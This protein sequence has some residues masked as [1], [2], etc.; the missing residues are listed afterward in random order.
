MPSGIFQNLLSRL[1]S[2]FS[3][4][5]RS[6][7][8]F[9][10]K[11][12]AQCRMVIAD[13][14]LTIT[15]VN[16]T[17]PL[18]D[19]S[20][21]DPY[22]AQKNITVKQVF[23]LLNVTPG[24]T[25]DNL[26]T[27]VA[28][29]G[30]IALV[31][32]DYILT[33]DTMNPVRVFTSLL[34]AIYRPLA[35]V[36]E[37]A[38]GDIDVAI[39]QLGFVTAQGDF[40]DY[41]GTFFNIPRYS[42]VSSQTTTSLTAG[43]TAGANATL[44]VGN[45]LG[46]QVGKYILVGSGTKNFERVL[47][48]TVPD[49]V[50][51]TANL[52]NNHDAGEPIAV[53]NGVR[54]VE[55]DYEYSIR[56]LWETIKP[57]L[58]NKAIE[59][60]LFR[61][62]GYNTTVVDMSSKVLLAD[63][64]PTPVDKNPILEFSDAHMV[65]D[66]FLTSTT[67]GFP[68][69]DVRYGLGERYNFGSIGVFV[70]IPVDHAFYPYT[71]EQIQDIVER[72]RAG[73]TTPW[74]TVNQVAKETFSLLDEVVTQLQA[75]ISQ[76]I[77]EG[78]AMLFG[79]DDFQFYA[80][81]FSSDSVAKMPWLQNNLDK[82]SL[83]D[84]VVV[85]SQQVQVPA[86]YQSNNESV[87]VSGPLAD[88]FLGGFNRN[89]LVGDTTSTSDDFQFRTINNQTLISPA[90]TEFVDNPVILN[91]QRFSD[92]YITPRVLEG[93]TSDVL[94]FSAS[95]VQSLSL[96]DTTGV[97]A[98][99][100]QTVNLLYHNFPGN[101]NYIQWS[102][103]FTNPIWTFVDFAPTVTANATVDPLGGNTADKIVF[104]ATDATHTSR[105]QQF[106][107]IPTPAANTFYTI[108]VWLRADTAVNN[109]SLIM[110][111]STQAIP[112]SNTP[113]ITTSWQR[114]TI[115]G[116]GGFD[117][118][119][120]IGIQLATSTNQPS[121]TIYAWGAQ[122][123]YGAS[124]STYLRS[125]SDTNPFSNGQRLLVA[126][127]PNTSFNQT[128]S[129]TSV[130]THNQVTA[131]VVRPS[132]LTNDGVRVQTHGGT[133][134]AARKWAW[135]AATNSTQIGDVIHEEVLITNNG[136]NTVRVD[137]HLFLAGST[138]TVA[139]GQTLKVTFDQTAT[140]VSTVGM[141]FGSLDGTDIDITV[142]KP[143]ITV[144]GSTLGVQSDFV[145]GSWVGLAGATAT[146]IPNQPEPYPVPIVD[147]GI[148]GTISTDT[149]GVTGLSELTGVIP[150]TDTTF[151]V[152]LVISAPT[153]ITGVKFDSVA[154]TQA[155][156]RN[157][158]VV[159]R[160]LEMANFGE[161]W[162]TN[163]SASRYWI[164]PLQDVNGN[165]YYM[166]IAWPYKSPPVVPALRIS[167]PTASI[168]SSKVQIAAGD[169][170][171]ITW[172]A[173]NSNGTVTLRQET[174]ATGA[175]VDLPVAASGTNQ[176][177]TGGGN[178]ITQNTR[179]HLIVNGNNG[180]TAE[181]IVTITI[182]AAST[183]ALPP[184]ITLTATP[185]VVE[186]C[187][188][189][190]TLVNYT[191]D[192]NSRQTETQIILFPAGATSVVLH[193]NAGDP[194]GTT[195]LAPKQ[196]ANGTF[197]PRQL[198]VNRLSDG[199]LIPGAWSGLET[200]AATFIPVDP[201]Q[202]QGQDISVNYDVN[203]AGSVL[204][205]Q[206]TDV[207]LP[208]NGNVY[209]I[210]QQAK[211]TLPPPP[212]F[213]TSQTT[214]QLLN[215]SDFENMATPGAFWNL[216]GEGEVLS[217]TVPFYNLLQWSE[218]L[219]Y[220]PWTHSGGTTIT[221]DSQTD[222][223]GT[224]FADAIAFTNTSDFVSQNSGVVPVVG[225]TYTFSIWLKAP[226]TTLCQ[227]EMN[228]S[229]LDGVSLGV[230]VTTTWTRFSLTHTATSAGGTNP[231]SVLL[232]TTVNGSTVYAWGAQL[233][234]SA[235]ATTYQRRLSNIT[236][237]SVHSG[238]QCLRVDHTQ[239]ISFYGVRQILT[240]VNQGANFDF[241]ACSP[242][243]TI[244]INAWAY[245]ESFSNGAAPVILI[246][247]WNSTGAQITTAA[248]NQNSL[249]TWANIFGNLVV[250][251][252]AASFTMECYMGL[253][254][255]IGR[256]DDI[257]L[258]LTH[259]VTQT[260]TQYVA[261]YSV[262][263]D[264]YA[265]APVTS[266]IPVYV[267]TVQQG[268]GPFVVQSMYKGAANLIHD[269]NGLLGSWTTTAAMIFNSS[270]GALTGGGWQ[271]TGTGAA[272]G[273]QFAYSKVINVVPGQTYTLS[274]YIDGTNVTVGSPVWIV[275]DPSIPATN[276]AIATATQT[277]GVSGRITK[278]FT[279][280]AG[281]TQ[282]VVLG[283]TNNC[284]VANGSTLTF[285]NP[286]LEVGSTATPYANFPLTSITEAIGPTIN[287][288]V[289]VTLAGTGF[290]SKM[291]VF[292]A[293]KVPSQTDPT[294]FISQL[295]QA[296]IVSL[297]WQNGVLTFIAPRLTY[298]TAGYPII[299]NNIDC[300]GR[301]IGTDSSQVLIY[302]RSSYRDAPVIDA[303]VPS[304]TCLVAGFVNKTVSLTG[305][306]FRPGA[307]VYI[308]NMTTQQAYTRYFNTVMGLRP[309][310]Y[311]KLSETGVGAVY[312]DQSGNNNT[313]TL[314]GTATTQN[315]AGLI[316]ATANGSVTFNGS[317]SISAANSSTLQNNVVTIVLWV[318]AANTS[319]VASLA[320]LINQSG[321]LTTSPGWSIHENDTTTGLDVR[322]DTSAGA[323]QFT[324]L[325]GVVLDGNVHMVA[326]AIDGSA[327]NLSYSIDGAAYTT[328]TFLQGTGIANTTA[329]LMMG[330]LVGGGFLVGTIDEVALFSRI[331]PAANIATLY[332]QGTAHMMSETTTVVNQ[333]SLYFTMDITD[334]GSYD[335]I[336]ENTDTSSGATK[337][338]PMVLMPNHTIP[339]IDQFG[340]LAPISV[341]GCA[342]YGTPFTIY[343]SC[344]KA[345]SVS[346]LSSDPA[347]QTALQPPPSASWPAVGSV[348]VPIT[349][350]G[351]TV[352]LIATNDCNNTASS[353][354]T[355]ND[356]ACDR[357]LA[358]NIV[359]TP[360][361]IKDRLAYKLHTQRTSLNEATNV[362]SI[363][364]IS[365]DTALSYTL[366]DA[367]DNPIAATLLTQGVA[368][369]AVTLTDRYVTANKNGIARVKGYW[370]GFTTVA[371]IY[372]QVPVP[373]SL[374]A[375][376][377]PIL[378]SNIG[379]IFQLVV[380]A[381]Y[382]DG[383]VKTVTSDPNIRYYDYDVKV[384][385][386]TAG[387]SISTNSL[388]T[389]YV[390]CSYFDSF[391][392]S[393]IVYTT[394]QV[395]LPDNCV[396]FE[397]LYVQPS[398][399]V[400]GNL[401]PVP[402][403]AT[404]TG[405]NGVTNTVMPDASGNFTF[406]Y[407]GVNTGTDTVVVNTTNPALT[408][409][410]LSVLWVNPTA[411]VSCAN[412]TGYFYV[413]DNTGVFD[414]NGQNPVFTQT[415]NSL[416]FNDANLGQN[417]LVGPAVVNAVLDGNGNKTA[418]LPVTGAGFTLGL[419]TLTAFNAIFT[420]SFV[421]KSAGSYTFTVTSDDGFVMGVGGGAV[422][423]GGSYVGVPTSGKTVYSQLPVMGANNIATGPVPVSVIVNFP[424]PGV[425]PFEFDWA[426]GLGGDTTF[427]VWVNG[428]P[429]VPITL[430]AAPTNVIP[431]P[432]YGVLT[433]T[434]AV[435]GPYIV[436]ETVTFNGTAY[437][438]N[439][440]AGQFTLNVVGDNVRSSMVNGT[441]A[442]TGGT[443]QNLWKYS[444]NQLLTASRTFKVNIAN[445]SG[446]VT[447]LTSANLITFPHAVI[448][449]FTAY[450]GSNPASAETTAT[451]TVPYG[452][453]VG[454]CWN[455]SNAV[456]VTLTV[457]SNALTAGN[458]VAIL[459][460]AENLPGAGTRYEVPLTDTTYILNAYST[461]GSVIQQSIV[462]T[463]TNYK[464]FTHDWA[465]GPWYA[466]GNYW[467]LWS[468]KI[469]ASTTEEVVR[470][471]QTAT[472]GLPIW[473]QGYVFDF[474][475]DYL[476]PI[477]GW[478]AFLPGSFDDRA[479]QRYTGLHEIADASI[480]TDGTRPGLQP[481]VVHYEQN[482]AQKD[483]FTVA[484]TTNTVY[485]FNLTGWWFWWFYDTWAFAR[486]VGNFTFSG[487][488]FA[489]PYARAFHHIWSYGFHTAVNVDPG[490]KITSMTTS[491]ASINAG[492]PVTITYTTTGASQITANFAQ[493]EQFPLTGGSFTVYPDKTTDFVI[494][495]TSPT[496]LQITGTVHVDVTPQVYY[497]PCVI[498]PMPRVDSIAVDGV[499]V[500]TESV[501]I[502]EDE[503]V[504]V[505]EI[506]GDH[507]LGDRIPTPEITGN[508]KIILTHQ[509]GAA[510]TALD[511]LELSAVANQYI[512]A[513]IATHPQTLAGIFTTYVMND[514]GIS[515]EKGPSR[516]FTVAVKIPEFVM[517]K[518]VSGYPGN[519][520]TLYLDEY[521]PVRDAGLTI[522]VGA[523]AVTPTFVG[524]NLTDTEF[525]NDLY[526]EILGRLPLASELN[527][528][529]AELSAASID[530]IGIMNS[531]LASPEYV[532]SGRN[533][534]VGVGT[535]LSVPISSK[536][537]VGIGLKTNNGLSPTQ[538][539]FIPIQ[540]PPQ[541]PTV[542][543]PC[544]IITG[545]TPMGGYA[546]D[547]INV[548]GTNFT[549]NTKILLGSSSVPVTTTFVSSTN[550]Q[551]TLPSYASTSIISVTVQDGACTDTHTGFMA[552]VLDS[553]PAGSDVLATRGPAGISFPGTAN[554][555]PTGIGAV[556]PVILTSTSLPPTTVSNATVGTAL[557]QPAVVVTATNSAAITT[558]AVNHA[559]VT[560]TSS[561]QVSVV[562]FVDVATALLGV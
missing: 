235:T 266:T 186:L 529:L 284:T 160:N 474:W 471:G 440:K 211:V 115:T 69:D 327:G 317:S 322:I 311:Y 88:G 358:I 484:P 245:C 403:N 354:L 308:P 159:I 136:T 7:T 250:P 296:D 376:P 253:P 16:T 164:I 314:S 135:L 48:L 507:F 144:N 201:T 171:N 155:N 321:F 404:V 411:A 318:K 237:P 536:T 347:V 15:A 82:P 151:T 139:A 189:N 86:Q 441:A 251:A 32:G 277:P 350:K 554:I 514:V 379:Q 157:V 344:S 153:S 335:I 179:F 61:G 480:S 557:T 410:A 369:Q 174:I 208:N 200:T 345:S 221:A 218:S 156:I 420:G 541:P 522:M 519:A 506:F 439:E 279:V 372:V 27:T 263:A 236:V 47:V 282:V 41:W 426:E 338:Q 35:Y 264:N 353:V 481:T 95:A 418:D 402:V 351:T 518:P 511:I 128:Y 499:S 349:T 234:K 276:L 104:A 550:L 17:V 62:T 520:V 100:G 443:L 341:K 429:V 559:T 485:Q 36:L 210:Q 386:V 202:V 428:A 408:S 324:H 170:I 367:N 500:V 49:S 108:S 229:G 231:I 451:L 204:R 419:G 407:Q 73:G 199:V 470:L 23:D 257:Q 453:P 40:L 561:A 226:V 122:I 168:S 423:I 142:A 460:F 400:A 149:S 214:A 489:V 118:S 332:Q 465:F 552:I 3:K 260:T 547:L 101:W 99:D 365:D 415:F 20:F 305:K 81:H 319:Q 172:A 270:A 154:L 387:G 184:S 66:G 562:K 422:R 452:A 293:N 74:F 206:G 51:I 50:T 112:V 498:M 309:V 125:A 34:W 188:S 526:S 433:L 70:D 190:S 381:T 129:V 2:V 413:G 205:F 273:F 285:S 98:N 25:V 60:L 283:D 265:T 38:K 247:Y 24:V 343:W 106:C 53:E 459:P 271:Y 356:L 14:R 11:P 207:P 175:I 320:G 94:Q 295:V 505:L 29:L 215:N 84:G 6:V 371:P 544:C 508:V 233:E 280:P 138:T 64:Y 527:S 33:P 37:Q 352:T 242:G 87:F 197:E 52:S 388:G 475:D 333:N 310:A 288:T 497:A 487:G 92:E 467:R 126:N 261:N 427:S 468:G 116:D 355:I 449:K 455:T 491:L 254:G 466:A 382:S 416:S 240:A 501:S 141:I 492:D 437:G 79:Y 256:W 545:I 90:T 329:S 421:I 267:Q 161:N 217:L 315:S 297:D 213:G 28:P 219:N 444:S 63:G 278:T 478:P 244:N 473:D 183:T 89:L 195:I 1:N 515:N 132:A 65:S 71:I 68:E 462:V 512:R 516:S 385:S 178:G 325:S 393:T 448:N 294:Q 21:A 272:A 166:T 26:A 370:N 243:D 77:D 560:S 103:D 534:S 380:T 493:N 258:S 83:S 55:P 130:T 18:I 43:A 374:T 131:K 362:Q 67:Q 140:A 436:G 397:R 523:T 546:G 39:Q 5:P 196:L 85:Q 162:N 425:Y 54:N 357:T 538:V 537:A 384:C 496:G 556:N 146:I 121:T 176:Y 391:D 406:S 540:P 432:S 209:H 227:I 316:T 78:R 383:T 216:G 331:L 19:I 366:V 107:T 401:I 105:I 461:D 58:N 134:G 434:P 252:N 533:V 137:D 307:Q 558:L 120:S 193:P 551:F 96:L 389:T 509:S 326:V 342:Y 346:F 486:G 330:D 93:F 488:V 373:I 472:V 150:S 203:Y 44:T 194:V 513:K 337:G 521:N 456:Q 532:K 180:Q 553:T 13:R 399:A 75:D 336:V 291:Q 72:H 173:T 458:N 177:S 539:E 395:G 548:F 530:R 148:G 447:A 212:P 281:Q 241:I 187:D 182:V 268:S 375:T 110:K 109:V 306:F 30:A 230:S 312:L 394:V 435:A 289:P 91:Y 111:K 42:T 414:S 409:N 124:A 392:P 348:T 303:I 127:C 119:N 313:G 292:L 494:T 165:V 97:T 542:I 22:D 56:L 555:A 59:E 304:T 290:S 198:T 286:Q 469:F 222:P 192:F 477:G 220:T 114:F 143:L 191:V 301:T 479:W 167:N 80:D 504:H 239:G 417:V 524:A 246:R 412:I 510:A 360:V 450:D 45:T 463:V 363:V 328:T 224:T 528:W 490:P 9:R 10:I 517:N 549:T 12:P 405:V 225:D 76:E 249:A 430:P 133:D 364:D 259:A 431:A 169:L 398:Y 368:S 163:Y 339:S 442:L 123:N 147:A 334:A 274:G 359:P 340:Y 152:P 300:V 390:H 476:S 457:K 8:A 158:P 4:D 117:N 57:R 31:E 396:G 502:P 361:V 445:N 145:T 503:A 113:P 377:T 424:Q 185:D 223:N 269:P 46:V 525:V 483:I 543:N 531:L 464:Y 181:A 299:V 287:Q 275:C 446:S 238:T 298:N 495:A 378:F 535:I 255:S 302:L 228:R 262:T 438:V 102:E 248:T 232:Q 482:V 454:L 323:N